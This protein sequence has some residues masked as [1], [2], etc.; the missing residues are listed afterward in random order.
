MTP[1]PTKHPMSSET[2]TPRTDE[3]EI[4]TQYH[5][6]NYCVSPGFARQLERE[7]AV[8]SAEK[9]EL[10]AALEKASVS[11]RRIASNNWSDDYTS[12]HS[13]LFRTIARETFEQ[14]KQPLTRSS[15]AALS[16]VEK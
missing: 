4:Y 16:G 1:Q 3:M 6:G 10:L 11:L 2:P 5:D 15:A 8:L 7:I 9:A 12:D 13:S 14:I